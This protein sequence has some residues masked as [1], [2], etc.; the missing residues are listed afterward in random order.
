MPRSLLS[1]SSL[2]LRHF[3]PLSPSLP[4]VPSI[5]QY[6]GLCQKKE[7]GHPTT[8]ESSL[9]AALGLSVRRASSSSKAAR[10]V[11]GMDYDALRAGAVPIG[12]DRAVTV[13]KR[14]LI[15]K[16]LS[17]YSRPWSTLRELIQNAAD[18]E[19]S[20]VVIK[21]KTTP[22]L[23]LPTPQSDDPSIHLRHVLHNHTVN[24]WVIG[25]NGHAFRPED[26]ARL[27]EIATGNPDEDKI[28]AFGVGFYSVF[29]ISERPSVFSGS[30]ALEFFWK[31]NDLRAQRFK[32]PK[33]TDTIFQLPVHDTQTSVPH[34]HELFS[35]CQFL[36]GSMTFVGLQSIDLFIDQWRI[37]HLQK[38]V[39]DPVNLGLPPGLSRT[40][41]KKLMRISQVTQQ[42]VQLEVEWMNVLDSTPSLRSA[43]DTLDVAKKSVFSF[44][45][46]TAGPFSQNSGR[47]GEDVKP[48]ADAMVQDIIATSRHKAFF[49]VNKASISTTVDHELGAEY[50]R[51]RKK[52]PPK[53]TNLSLLAQS[54]EESTASHLNEP[55]VASKLFKSVVPD[56]KGH[57]YI[58]F[59][60]SQTTGLSAHLEIPALVPTVEREQLDLNSKHI[61]TW[62]MEL[63]RAAGLVARISWSA[64]TTDLQDRLSRYPGMTDKKVL[65]PEELQEVLPAVKWQ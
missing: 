8:L 21:I 52:R 19:A 40:T 14:S 27:Q 38:S 25:N 37:L 62:N 3:R 55:A 39:A 13:N 15:D 43:S 50:L 30:E 33:N 35:L 28:G 10:M 31:E 17:R 4:S 60:T 54:Y 42:A 12:Q 58:G 26:W 22:S 46:R 53:L 48:V 24:E 65:E 32:S 44:F 45:K 1:P 59:T 7:A 11:A 56:S 6:D 36:T 23:R 18:A 34:G 2:I 20:Q 57:I 9:S 41:P 5:Y 49:H 51:L 47:A 64:A 63:L 61:R 29:S 16:Q